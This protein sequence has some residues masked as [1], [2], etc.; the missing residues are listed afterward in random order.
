MQ[1]LTSYQVFME[2]PLIAGRIFLRTET[3]TVVCYD[4][5]KK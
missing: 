1:P 4:L 2:P 3:G 5:T